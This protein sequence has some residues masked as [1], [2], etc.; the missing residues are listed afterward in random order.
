M[1][2][3]PIKCGLGIVPVHRPMGGLIFQYRRRRRVCERNSEHSAMTGTFSC[4]GRNAAP[5]SVRS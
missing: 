4:L 2:L 1:N 5:R 3:R